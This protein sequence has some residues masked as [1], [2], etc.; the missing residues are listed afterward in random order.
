MDCW[1]E[2]FDIR[3]YLKNS[4]TEAEF[5]SILEAKPPDKIASILD[6]VERAKQIKKN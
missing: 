2:T 3:T 4:L 1:W 5:K 6:L